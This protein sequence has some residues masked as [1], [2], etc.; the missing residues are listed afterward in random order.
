V[1]KLYPNPSA[2]NISIQLNSPAS[3][4][5][6]CILFDQKGGISMQRSFNLSTGY[7]ELTISMA[8][9]PAGIYHLKLIGPDS[10]VIF[11]ERVVRL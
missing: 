3:M 1:V 2:G 10:A 11:S 6:A 7:N 9:L 8:S 5:A 4:S